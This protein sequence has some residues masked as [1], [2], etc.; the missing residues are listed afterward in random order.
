MAYS[1]ALLSFALSLLFCLPSMAKN[2]ALITKDSDSPF[3]QAVKAGCVEEAKKMGHTCH[4]IEM[5]DASAKLQMRL[6][7]ENLKSK[8]IDALAIAVIQSEHTINEIKKL[9]I[10][11]ITVDSDFSEKDISQHKIKRL[12]YVGTDNYQLGVKLANSYIDNFDDNADICILSG[13]KD[14]SNLNKRIKGFQETLTKRGFSNQYIDQCPF[15]NNEDLDKSLSQMLFAIKKYS[16]NKNLTIASMGGFAQHSPETYR[17]ALGKYKGRLEMQKIKIIS[18][19]A[20]PA[21]VKLLEQ[22]YSHLNIG[23]SPKEMGKKTITILDKV[24]KNQNYPKKLH[25]PIRV[26]IPKRCS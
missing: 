5:P 7:F 20:L 6:L 26:C 25:T 9:N 8:K 14:S 12:S 10:P 16:R 3:F 1:R 18:I 19:D 23:Q 15:Y 11:F 2:I 4:Y 17:A 13:H 21:Q 24:L 22:G